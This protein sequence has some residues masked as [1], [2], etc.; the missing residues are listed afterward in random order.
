MER[1]Q[2]RAHRVRVSLQPLQVGANLRGVLVTQ[3]AI[4]LQALDNDAFQLCRD[5]GVEAHRSNRSFTQNG[6][7]DSPRRIASERWSS[8]SHLIEHHPEREQISLCVQPLAEYLLRGHVGDG[9]QG[10]PWP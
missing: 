8:S 3:I 5:L 2:S 7:K 10:S 4:F 9:T 6:V 1:C